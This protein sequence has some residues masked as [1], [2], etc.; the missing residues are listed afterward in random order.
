MTLERRRFLQITAAGVVA[1]L[2]TT[3]WAGDAA[4]DVSALDRP[5]LLTML[6]PERVREL[7]TRYRAETPNENTAGSLR[8][9]ISRTERRTLLLRWTPRG[10][11]E[12]QIENDFAAG[13][14]VLIDGWV[15]SATEARQCALFSLTSA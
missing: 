9:A 6:G 15:L 11:L 8:A 10:S 14:T 1:G 2:T 13:R 4:A 5:E 3:A 7:G 12:N